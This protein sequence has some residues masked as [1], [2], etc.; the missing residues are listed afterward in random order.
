LF[1]CK[2]REHQVFRGVYYI[3]KLNTNIIILGLLDEVGFQIIID[4]GVLKIKDGER[5]LLAK[6]IRS[7]NRLYVI[8]VELAKHVCLH[9]KGS[10]SAWLWH[11]RFGH[12]NFP[13]LRK[14][15][16]E[17]LV[18]GL[19][20]LEQVDQVCSGCLAGKHYRAS[21]LQQ[22]AFR[23]NELLELVHG[24]LCGPITPAT[25]SGN[26]YFILLVDDRS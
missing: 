26:K 3:P 7:P 6:V 25:P 23:A 9:A 19:P 14:L 5:R 20:D 2:T 12:M 1:S 17:G 22:E 21:F 24:D 10:E 8:N 15:A 13:A 11:A 16:W 4:G 18:H